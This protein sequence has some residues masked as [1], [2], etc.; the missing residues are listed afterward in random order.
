MSQGG[1]MA[2]HGAKISGLGLLLAS[3]LAAC[4]GGGS[5]VQPGPVVPPPGSFNLQSAM[6][7][8]VKSGLSAN[9]NLSGTAIVSG[10]STSFTGTGLLTLSP[11]ASGLFNGMTATLQTETISG[12]VTVSGHSAPYTSSVVNAYEGATAAILGESQSNNEFDVASA[13]IT[14][15]TTVGTSAVSLGTLSRYADSTLSVVLGTTQISVNVAMISVDPGSPEVVQFTYKSFD[16]S[17]ALVETDTVS[18]YLTEG[19][20]LSF[21]SATAQNASGTLN[22]MPQ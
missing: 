20:I 8:L 3:V 9:V 1:I 13:P 18:Y 17:Q 14:I 19:S 6:A 11:G 22:V 15:P 21:Y 12:T 2:Q 4:G 5:T 7:A 10:T 16:T